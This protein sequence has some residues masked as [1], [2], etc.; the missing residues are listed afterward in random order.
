[1]AANTLL[2]ERLLAEGQRRGVDVRVPPRALCTDN[3]AMV[4][5]SG[6]FRLIAGE[7]DGLDLDCY[8]RP[9]RA[10]SSSAAGVDEAQS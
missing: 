10:E 1:V 7:R 3:A 2:R 4:A 5:V 8:P 6:T 9:V